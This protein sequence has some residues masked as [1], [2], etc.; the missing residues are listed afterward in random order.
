M[1]IVKDIQKKLEEG[2]AQH[3]IRSEHTE[4]EHWYRYIP[5]NELFGSATTKNSAAGISPHL[6][7]WS[8]KVAVDYIYE[9]VIKVGATPT[10]LEWESIARQ[11][12]QQHNDMFEDAGDIGTVGHGVVEDY[13]NE[14]IKTETRSAS[15]TP[16]ITQT[17][18][19]VHAIARSFEKFCN[20]IPFIPIVSEMKVA[21]PKHKYAGTLDLL[22]MVGI[23]KKKG[24][25]PH[26]THEIYMNRSTQNECKIECEKCGRKVDYE[27]CL[28]DL[29]TSNSIYK[30]EY[31]KQVSAYAEALKF[32]T[33]L[34]P[35]KLFILRLDKKQAKYELAIIPHPSKA[36]KVFLAGAK[37][38]DWKRE[39]YEKV[40]PFFGKQTITLDTLSTQPAIDDFEEIIK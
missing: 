21:H 26:C 18:P 9:K 32:M 39:S 16:F 10:P 13:L 3:P 38:D 8:A 40:T 2:I 7:Y 22:G 37:Q 36:F 20:E 31:A 27:F 24:N 4:T 23:E 33:G 15:I 6:K 29:K 1:Q 25:N 11:A 12:V 19:R 35:K 5:T 34:K 28:I 30:E 14:W 17:D